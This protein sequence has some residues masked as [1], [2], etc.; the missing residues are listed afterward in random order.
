MNNRHLEI[1]EFVRY[2]EV[3]IFKYSGE[4]KKVHVKKTVC[5]WELFLTMFLLCYK[6]TFH[7]EMSFM[8][9]TEKLGYI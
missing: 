5:Y 4:E 8:S 7:E 3:Q 9:Q 2:S 6:L 1:T